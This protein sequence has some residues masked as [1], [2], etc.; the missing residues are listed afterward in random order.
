[1][2]ALCFSKLSPYKNSYEP[3]SRLQVKGQMNTHFFFMF[4]VIVSQLLHKGCLSIT[5]L[6]LFCCF[7]NANEAKQTGMQ[8]RKSQA[9]FLLVKLAFLF[10]FAGQAGIF[11]LPHVFVFQGLLSQCLGLFQPVE[12]AGSPLLGTSLSRY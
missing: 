7:N 10:F 8:L 12:L 4:L 5:A 9:G 6:K 3:L 2:P 11:R 1:M